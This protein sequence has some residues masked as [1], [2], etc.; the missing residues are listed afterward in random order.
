MKTLLL[1]KEKLPRDKPWD[2]GGF[3]YPLTGGGIETAIKSGRAAA[4]ICSEAIDNND[5]SLKRFKKYESYCSYF[6]KEIKKSRLQLS[7]LEFCM[8]YKLISRYL[9]DKFFRYII[10]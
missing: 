10:K 5:F 2:A 1:E 9:V 3:I 7:T 6:V 4:D 8:K